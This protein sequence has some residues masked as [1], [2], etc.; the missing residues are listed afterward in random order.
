MFGSRLLILFRHYGL[1]A[2]G[3]EFAV[4]FRNSYGRA[5]LHT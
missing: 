5:S 3:N 4:F 2:D 1:D